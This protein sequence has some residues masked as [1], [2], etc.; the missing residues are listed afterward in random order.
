[1]E[2]TQVRVEHAKNGL[3]FTVTVMRPN[4]APQHINNLPVVTCLERCGCSEDEIKNHIRLTE[5]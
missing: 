5:D 2:K 4:R 1:M 3:D